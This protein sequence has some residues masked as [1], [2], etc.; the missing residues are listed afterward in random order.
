MRHFLKEKNQKFQVFFLKS[1]LHFLSL[2]YSADFRRSRLV[3]IC[4]QF[5]QFTETVPHKQTYWLSFESIYIG[6]ICIHSCTS[7]DASFIIKFFT[8][9]C[10]DD[11]YFR[12][13]VLR[14]WEKAHI[15]R[16]RSMNIDCPLSFLVGA[17][18]DIY[19]LYLSCKG[20]PSLRQ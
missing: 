15:V 18:L 6:E 13:V 9:L 5:S 10:N 20:V 19:I 4:Y 17:F 3:L 2:R 11:V 12:Y 14:W 16:K 1:L 8:L 7:E